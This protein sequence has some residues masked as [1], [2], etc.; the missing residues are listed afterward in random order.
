MNLLEYKED[1]L[2]GKLV[3]ILFGEEELLFK[4]NR[5]KQ[6]LKEGLVRDYLMVYRTKNGEKISV[7]FSGSM[8]K[9]K[10][11]ELISIVGIAGI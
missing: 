5:F 8:M 4:G 3:G 2:I 6:L 1:E 9:N 10:K 11:G 7:N